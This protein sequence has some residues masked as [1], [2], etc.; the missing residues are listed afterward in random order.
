MYGNKRDHWPN[1]VN[2]KFD[3]TRVWRIS[4]AGKVRRQ[5][6]I[7]GIRKLRKFLVNTVW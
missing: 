5:L 7:T 2:T 3:G 6:V 4:S 1:N